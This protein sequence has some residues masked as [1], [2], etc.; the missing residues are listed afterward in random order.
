MWLD[1]FDFEIAGDSNGGDLYTRLFGTK[2]WDL[3]MDLTAQ[4]RTTPELVLIVYLGIF[5]GA[6]LEF[7][8]S[9]VSGLSA[10]GPELIGLL[11]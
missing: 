6:T 10:V 8:R 2:H 11:P 9:S 3:N 1:I 5:P 7:A 4:P